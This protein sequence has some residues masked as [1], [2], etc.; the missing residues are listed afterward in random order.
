MAGSAVV[1]SS[2]DVTAVIVPSIYRSTVASLGE[3]VGE[4]VE[5]FDVRC[6]RSLCTISY[7]TAVG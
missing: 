6:A 4:I 2:A 3:G 5:R 1:V 7:N